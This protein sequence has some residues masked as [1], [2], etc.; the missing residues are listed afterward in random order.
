[1]FCLGADIGSLVFMGR[2]GDLS[3]DVRRL[4]YSAF[5]VPSYHEGVTFRFS[6]SAD[7][8]GDGR[9]RISVVLEP[10]DGIL[11]KVKVC[12]PLGAMDDLRLQAME[13]ID[14]ANSY[15]ADV[16]DSEWKEDQVVSLGGFDLRYRYAFHRDGDVT[17]RFLYRCDEKPL[18]QGR[19]ISVDDDGLRLY[20]SCGGLPVFELV[21][22]PIDIRLGGG[23]IGAE[24]TDRSLVGGERERVLYF[25]RVQDFEVF[26]GVLRKLFE[27]V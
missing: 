15:F 22:G 8:A 19:S 1:M 11:A 7:I 26:L 17:A 10:R 24:I 9:N 12:G 4:R 3:E 20:Y 25:P 23:T 21:I 5:L 13:E 2:W 16:L 27:E 14:L 18:F 6:G